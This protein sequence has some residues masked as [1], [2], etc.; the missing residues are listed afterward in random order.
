MTVPPNRPNLLRGAATNHQQGHSGPQVETQR[1][2]AMNT[3]IKFAAALTAVALTA[4]L[5]LPNQA[6]ARGRGLAIG[7]IGAG[8]VAG[9][10]YAASAQPVYV[11]GGYRS[12]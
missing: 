5:A 9:S 10:I 3:T 11:G 4:T 2:S 7:L 6:E 1:E 12:C 8:I